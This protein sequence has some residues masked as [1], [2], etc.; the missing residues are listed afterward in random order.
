[1][2]N[3]EAIKALHLEGGLEISGNARRL[4]EFMEA[5]D[6]AISALH[7][8]PTG[9]K[10]DYNATEI[11][12]GCNAPLTPE[13][14]RGMEGKWVLVRSKEPDAPGDMPALIQDGCATSLC[15]LG[16]T[17]IIPDICN[18]HFLFEDYEKTWL[19]YAYPHA[20]IDR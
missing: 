10:C 17:S 7:N 12:P 2:T 18:V 19:A 6:M 4:A 14:L 13:Q 11:R 15:K 3:K 20:K 1:M 5:L 16:S 9:E 8:Q